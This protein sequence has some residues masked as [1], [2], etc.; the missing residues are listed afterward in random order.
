MAAREMLRLAPGEWAVLGVV[1]ERPTHGFAIAQLMVPDGAIG[2]VWTM[3]RPVVYQALH[4][5]IQ[6]GLI[7]ERA[8]VPSDR[9]PVRTIVAAT[10]SGKRA[11]RG[12][13]ATPVGHIRDVRSLFLLKLAL[14]DR[15]DGDPRPLIDAQHER[16]ALLVD[17]LRNYRDRADGFE[18]IL[19]SWRLQSCE[20]TLE[21]LQAITWP[22]RRAERGR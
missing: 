10:P 12:W 3:P 21:F 6:A 20:A 8:T 16:F 15:I 13:L 18:R 5:L 2:R 9:G 17:P 19:A 22:D 1:A 11:V 7:A 4:K 14:L